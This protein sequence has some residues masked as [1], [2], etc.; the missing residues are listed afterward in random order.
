MCTGSNRLP[1]YKKPS[2]ISNLPY[3]LLML[4]NND[5][6]YSATRNKLELGHRD[7]LEHLKDKSS[8]Y[9]YTDVLIPSGKTL[10]DFI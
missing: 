8:E 2:A 3:Y 10:K 9:Y 7:L 4:P 6:Y 5:D 1:T